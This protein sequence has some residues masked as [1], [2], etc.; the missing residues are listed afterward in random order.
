[1]GP[2]IAIVGGGLFTPRLCEALAQ[3]IDLP[4]VELRLSARRQERL[5]IIANH[6]ARRLAPA[7]PGW[8]VQPALSLEAACEAASII[9]LLVRVGGL[10]ARAW[11]EAFPRQFGLV[12]DEGLGPGGVANAW[13]TVP[14]LAT[15]ARTI[16]QVA[17]T[18]RIVN[19]MAPLGVTTRL[20][21]DRGLDAIGLCELPLVTL[22]SWMTQPELAGGLESWHYGGL[23][24]LGWYWDVRC[25]GQDVLRL[26]ADHPVDD[27]APIDRVTLDRYGAAPLRYFYEVFDREA[28]RR[29]KLE[30]SAHRAAELS[31]LTETLIRRFAESPGGD[32]PEAEARR[33]PWLDQAAAP[34]VSALLGGSAHRGFANLRNDGKMSE[35]PTDIVVEVPITVS[36]DGIRPVSPGPL[37]DR[38]RKFL[39]QAAHSESLSFQ[40][41]E[42][43]DPALLIEAIRAL[44]LS[45]PEVAVQEL[46]TLAQ[47]SS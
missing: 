15:I 7:R 30:R 3:A 24:H 16:K 27:G 1:M 47:R 38:V 12:G 42:Q 40:A 5:R 31:G 34:I 2:I 41:S 9:I 21:L 17:P 10:E 20:L 46:A 23:N 25:R 33:T 45:I 39:H 32:I 35:L 22:K 11:D 43:R 36:S 13:R 44:P 28:G 37:P 26:V 14:E 4:E 6:S 18:T 19:L 8:S 29:L